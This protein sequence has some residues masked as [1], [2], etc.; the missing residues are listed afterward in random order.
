MNSSYL[1]PPPPREAEIAPFQPSSYPPP[2]PSPFHRSG[3]AHIAHRP[4]GSAP[5]GNTWEGKAPVSQSRGYVSPD[6]SPRD[7]DVFSARPPSGSLNAEHQPRRPVSV[8]VPSVYSHLV[9]H[10]HPN[11]I[12]EDVGRKMGGNGHL[13][14]F[15]FAMAGE[16]EMDPY[17]NAVMPPPGHR[18][19]QQ[20]MQ[21]KGQQKKKVKK[22]EGKQA[23]FLTK[24]YS[25]LSQPEYSHI[26]RWDESGESIVIENPEELS[27]KILPV[28]YRQSRFASF[29]RQ[30]NIYGFNRKLS[31][32]NVEKGICDPDA[33]TWSH[34]FLR[35]DSTKDEIL[36]FKR[37]VPPRPTQA[38]KRRMSMGVVYHPM[39]GGE[40]EASPT[41]SERSLEWHSPPNPY[42]SHLL[43]DVDE[44]STFS[45]PRGDYFASGQ[46]GASMMYTGPHGRGQEEDAMSPTSIRF[47][48]NTP[49]DRGVGFPI[50]DHL[51]S[52]NN[53]KRLSINIPRAQPSLPPP[54]PRQPPPFI[55]ASHS[56]SSIVPQSAPANAGSFPIPIRVTQEHIRTRS[57]QVEPPSAMIFSP[58]GEVRGQV[59]GPVY[60]GSI[61]LG[62]GIGPHRSGNENEQ[63]ES[64]ASFDT[65]DSTWARRGF[66]DLTNPMSFDTTHNLAT[67]PHSLPVDLGFMNPPQGMGMVD[68]NIPSALSEDSPNTI[69]PGVYQAGFSMPNIPISQRHI[70]SPNSYSISKPEQTLLSGPPVAGNR[71]ATKS[72]PMAARP[73]AITQTKQSRRASIS[74]S[75]YSAKQRPGLPES[76][77]WTSNTVNSFGGS[78]RMI[79]GL[80]RDSV[81]GSVL[82]ESPVEKEL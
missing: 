65:S 45:L 27:D 55:L 62:L 7:E 59:P 52:M 11:H 41:S 37:R 77:S 64:I 33:S 58:I 6:P 32:R 75:P 47:D 26:I 44:E 1:A 57:A 36:S 76:A 70:S 68:Q 54:L 72:P 51:G 23:T 14:D 79:G 35:R 38:Q 74:N 56:P 39:S 60:S 3:S 42:Q 10:I 48:Y 13:H 2:S 9:P 20:N 29:S 22:A 80:R 31:L 12:Q 82:E 8:P 63:I 73:S 66:I 49:P 4:H 30:L 50:N 25:L 18:S 34:P 19:V 5:W 28:V 24:L 61:G 53:S 17:Y 46:P 40:G 16:V 69:S 15:S 21:G 81:S 78:L 67:S 43:P 71:N